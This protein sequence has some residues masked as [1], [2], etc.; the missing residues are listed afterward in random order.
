MAELE[1]VISLAWCCCGKIGMFIKVEL[2]TL[3]LSIVVAELERSLRQNYR[4]SDSALPLAKLER[5]S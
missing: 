1:I 4:H 3:R 2:K 5:S